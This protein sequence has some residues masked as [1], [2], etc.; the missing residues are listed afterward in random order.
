MDVK[1]MAFR[2]KMLFLS[3]KNIIK[4]VLKVIKVKHKKIF[5]VAS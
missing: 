4:I 3:Y 5:C 2:K 1:M